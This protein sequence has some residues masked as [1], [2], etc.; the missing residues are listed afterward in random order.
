M[1]N[2]TI[3][4]NNS[5]RPAPKW[6]RKFKKIFSN[7]ENLVLAVLMIK[8]RASDSPL[9]LIIKLSTSFVNPPVKVQLVRAIIGVVMLLALM[10]QSTFTNGS[11]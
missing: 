1:A 9:L 5:N 8:G 3:S 2:T 11:P 6:F 4:A 7:T 10:S